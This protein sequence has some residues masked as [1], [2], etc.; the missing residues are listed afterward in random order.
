MSHA[1]SRSAAA[2]MIA[3]IADGNPEARLREFSRARRTHDSRS[4]NDGVE[5]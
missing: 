2:H 4:H 3:G 1:G 5:M